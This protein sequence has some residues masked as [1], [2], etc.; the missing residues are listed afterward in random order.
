MVSLCIF[1][2]VQDW[3][4]L[5]GSLVIWHSHVTCVFIA[6]VSYI[7]FIYIYVS[8]ACSYMVFIYL[9]ISCMCSCIMCALHPLSVTW[10]HV[11]DSSTCNIVCCC[12]NNPIS[13]PIGNPSMLRLLCRSMLFWHDC[14]SC[15]YAPY[16]LLIGMVLLLTVP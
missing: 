12:Y 13:A 11:R 9:Y 2:V 5:I 10:S 16:D 1:G 4:C 6:N 8:L 3:Y 15:F 7:A 14:S